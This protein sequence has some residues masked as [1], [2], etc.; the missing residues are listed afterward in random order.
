LAVLASYGRII[1]QAILD[2][3]PLGIINV[4][5]SLLPIYRGPTPIEQAILDGATKTGVSIMR[6][7]AGMD[8][9]PIYKQKTL[10]LM[11]EETKTDLARQL[12]KLG[13]DLLT[14]VLPAIGDGSLKPRQQPHPSRATYSRLLAKEDSIID[15]HKSAEQLEREIRAYAGWPKS[16]TKIGD[17]EI[18]ITKA[19]ALPIDGE[20]AKVEVLENSG[21]LI[22][23]CGHGYLSI[24]NIKPIGKKEMT[25]KEFIR[26]YRNRIG[27]QAV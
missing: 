18:I 16:R 15:W 24:K 27:K 10:H 21:E 20:P 5:P 11:G 6:L 26:G 19:N 7:T 1:P 2:E 4:H 25:A 17:I 9:G 23:Y 13:A 14:E 22:I 3:F 8:E 12:Q